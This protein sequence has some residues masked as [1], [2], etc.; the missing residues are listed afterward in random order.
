MY[1]GLVTV[2]QLGR[3]EL[4]GITAICHEVPVPRS[5]HVIVAVVLVT[6]V[7]ITSTTV[8][9]HVLTQSVLRQSELSTAWMMAC[10]GWGPNPFEKLI[11]TPETR[12]Q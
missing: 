12:W 6:F 10:L 8:L 5:D 9:M 4:N 3:N 11:P 1:V 7:G 2:I